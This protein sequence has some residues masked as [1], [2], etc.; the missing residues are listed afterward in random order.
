MREAH[1]PESLER[2]RHGFTR[3]KMDGGGLV[4]ADAYQTVHGNPN[5]RNLR[6]VW[7]I[8]TF[9]FPG[10]HFA[11]FP[12]KLIEPCI[13]A[14]TSMKGCCS[15]CGAPRKRIVESDRQ[16]TRPGRDNV[17][18]DTGMANRDEQRHVTEYKTTGWRDTCDCNTLSVPCTVLDPFMGSGTTLLVARQEG[19]RGIGIELN[20]GYCDMA[21]KRLAQDCFDFVT[22]ET[23]T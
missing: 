1:K 5:G 9:S 8:P 18:D 4:M 22:E 15:E 13:R 14:G 16:P 23:P 21:T 3:D 7:T 19:C 12:P 6:D 20:R 10:A 17:S 11:T 2:Y